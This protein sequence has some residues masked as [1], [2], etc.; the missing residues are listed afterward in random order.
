MSSGIPDA[1]NISPK[2]GGSADSRAAGSVMGRKG[3]RM[4]LRAPAKYRPYRERY[5]A[6]AA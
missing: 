2:T 6:C 4:K 1:L 5:R 3:S